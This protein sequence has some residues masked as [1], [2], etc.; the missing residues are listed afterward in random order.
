MYKK[1]SKPLASDARVQ[2]TVTERETVRSDRGLVLGS[3]SEVSQ[4][5][6]KEEKG[7]RS[8]ESVQG[9]E[10]IVANNTAEPVAAAAVGAA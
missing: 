8:M 4:K 3:H 1:A 5:H 6:S 10:G 9:Q 2:E 7:V